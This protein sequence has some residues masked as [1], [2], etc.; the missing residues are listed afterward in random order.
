MEPE[1]LLN[2]LVRAFLYL[3]LYCF[4]QVPKDY[5]PKVDIDKFFECFSFTVEGTRIT[6]TGLKY[7]P[8]SPPPHEN[9]GDSQRDSDSDVSMV[10]TTAN[11]TALSVLSDSWNSLD[12]DHQHR[13][14]LDAYGTV[15]RVE[16]MRRIRA[17][18]GRVASVIPV[19]VL[20]PRS[21]VTG[22][23]IVPGTVETCRPPKYTK[24]STRHI[25]FN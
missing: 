9:A 14:E 16:L 3:I 20:E 5:Q 10:D 24:N 13:L 2:H 6:P 23:F 1:S 17:W 12:A 11:E 25:Y 21:R 4:M 8:P 19:V 15:A 7:P 18:H 22:G